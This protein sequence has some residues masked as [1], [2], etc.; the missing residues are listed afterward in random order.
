MV[1]KLGDASYRFA[2]RQKTWF[3]RWERQGRKIHWLSGQSEAEVL[4]EAE[5]LIDNY[6]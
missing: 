5:A 4:S 2:K 3:K 6:L 1:Q